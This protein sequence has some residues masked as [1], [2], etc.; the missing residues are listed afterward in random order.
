MSI[1][2]HIDM[3]FSSFLEYIHYI[4]AHVP[5]T[6][7]VVMGILSLALVISLIIRKKCSGYGAVVL[8]ITAFVGLFLLDTAVLIRYFGLMNHGSGFGFKAEV[9]GF[10]HVGKARRVEMLSNIAVFIPF[11]FFLSEFLSTKRKF[12][13]RRRIRY[14]SLTAF[15]LSLSIECLQLVFNAGYFELTDLVMNTVGGLIGAGATVLMRMV[16][17]IEKKASPT[18]GRPLTDEDV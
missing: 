11:G 3:F 2:S 8:G 15:G 7:W 13:A 16:L 17:G 18:A 9:D 6:H 5:W 4:F 1:V 12:S 10:L 14:V